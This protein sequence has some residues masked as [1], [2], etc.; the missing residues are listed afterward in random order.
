[1]I[2]KFDISFII[3]TWN[4]VEFIKECVESYVA[5]INK[6][7]LSA[8]F[9]IVDNGS[10]DNTLEIIKNKILPVLPDSCKLILIELEKN[11]GTTYS[12]NVGLKRAAGSFIVICDSD[13]YFA[14]GSWRDII[15]YLEKNSEVG[16]L[17][18]LLMYKDETL[19]RS[20]KR[21]PIIKDKLLKLKQIFFGINAKSSDQYL[22]FPWKSSQEVDTAISAFWIFKREVLEEIGLFDEKIFYAPED[23][24]YCLRVWKS[25]KKV[26]FYP[27]FKIVHNTQQI[28]HKKPFSLIALSHFLGLGYYFFKHNYFLSRK[29]VYAKIKDIKA[30]K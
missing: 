8:E 29:K 4:S 6:E 24:D 28:S 18:P 7:N 16:I 12:R 23:L 3:L 10:L 22:E 2:K 20:V 27:D 13:T 25:G 15:N 30:K 19:Q 14:Q 11:Y 26:V 9:L 17:A 5:S 1:M 21:F